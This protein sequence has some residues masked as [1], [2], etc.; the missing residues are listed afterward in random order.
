MTE[1]E[2]VCIAGGRIFCTCGKL[3]DRAAALSISMR[4]GAPGAKTTV[5]VHDH[6]K[7]EVTEHWDDRVDVTMKPETIRLK[8]PKVAEA[9]SSPVS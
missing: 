1:E 3:V 6:H 4:P 5:D 7:V 2:H 8:T 9:P